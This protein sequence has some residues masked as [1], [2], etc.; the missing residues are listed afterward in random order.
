MKETFFING[1]NSREYDSRQLMD[2]FSVVYQDFA[3]YQIS[4]ADNIRLG[5]QDGNG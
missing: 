2:M 5:E 1:R 3:R 4:F